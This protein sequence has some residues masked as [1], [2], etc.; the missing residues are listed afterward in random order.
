MK[1]KDPS[2]IARHSASQEKR[3]LPALDFDYVKVDERS[4][5]DLLLFSY[6][7]SKLIQYYNSE[8]QPEG[9]WSEFLEDEIVILARIAHI[10][11]TAIEKKFKKH[12]D[13][14][15]LFKSNAKKIHYLEQAFQDIYQVALLFDA[16]YE[17]FRQIENFANIQLQAR[18]EIR[19]SISNRLS[20]ALARLKAYDE[21]ASAPEALGQ[22]I[23]L[24][25]T[26]FGM[27]WDL[28]SPPEEIYPY[29]GDSLAEKIRYLTFELQTLF[30]IFYETLIYIKGQAKYYLHK[31]FEQDTHYPEVA[32]LLAFL[33]LYQI[34]QDNMN[35]LSQRYLDFYYYQVLK[36][37]KKKPVHDTVYLSFQT[38]ENA[39]F[40]Q[41]KAG[42]A[43]IGGEY[44][45]GENIIYTANED[46]WVNKTQVEKL[47]TV[48]L[49]SR[50]LN[51][52]GSVKKL[53]T[54]IFSNEI[55]L[56][57]IKP[58]PNRQEQKIYPAFGE[59][60]SDK[61]E[62]E[63]TMVSADVG[64]AI[65]SPSLLLQEG[66]RE[67][68]I[69]LQ[70]SDDSFRYL[71]Q[72]LGDLSF[73]TQDSHDE[74]F[75]KSFLEA[76]LIQITSDEGWFRVSKYV[77]SRERGDERDEKYNCLKVS[78][79]LESSDPPVIAYDPALHAGNFQTG[80]PMVKFVLNSD[81]YI[82][83]YSLLRNLILDKITIDTHVTGVKDLVLYSD[84]G[85]LNPT[86]PFY[87]FGSVPSVGSY[88]IIGKNEV[89][90][91]SLDDLEIHIEWFNLPK[92]SNGFQGYYEEYNADLDNTSFEAQLSIL[93]EGRWKP[94]NPQ[95][96]QRFKLFRT[97]Q[98]GF[99]FSA[100]N[101]ND[102]EQENG[103]NGNGGG[104]GNGNGGSNEPREQPQPNG[105]LSDQTQLNHVDIVKI[106]LP[107]NYKD[108]GK[109]L[110]YSNTVQRGFI[111]LELCSPGVAFAST[112]YP[113]V[114][115]EIVMENARNGLI[116]NVKRGFSGK[117]GKRMPNPPY[118]PQIK[119]L[120]L[121]YKTSSVISL[122]ERSIKGEKSDRRGQF[123]HIY[124]FG[125]NLVYPDKSKQFTP[126]LPE[127]NYEGA[128]LIGL[129][130][131]SVPQTVSILFEMQ[132]GYTNTSED[133]PPVIEWSYLVDDQW[134]P[135][136]ES[137]ILRDDTQQFIKTGIILLELPRDLKNKNT[138]L[139]PALYW[140]RV[141][142]VNHIEVTSRIVSISTQV[143]TASLKNL[144]EKDNHLNQALPAFS[145]SRSVSNIPGIQRLIQPLPSFGGKPAET[146][147]Q[148]YT[149]VSERLRHKQRVVSAWDYER[150]I[151]EQ[152]PEI[153][154]ATCL[155]NMSSEKMNQ[156]GSV[157][158]V[159]K[160]YPQASQTR[161]LEPKV[162]SEILY[163]I[164]DY[165][166][167]YLSPFVH[168][169]IRN[170]SYERVRIIC[171]VQLAKGYNYGFFVQKLNEDI[172][173]YLLGDIL[174]VTQTQELGGKVNIS[175]V[176]SYLRTLPYVDFITKFSMIQIA[177]DPS[178]KYVLLD[179]AREDDAK[180]FLQATKP[181]ATLIPAEEH[182]ISILDEKEEIK[183]HQAGIED[184]ELGND[185]IIED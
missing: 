51:L 180:S 1:S 125:D 84:I 119:S 156:P 176:L 128:L 76:F 12:L 106:K 55:P 120:S 24:D 137:K 77:V 61:S 105:R 67:I 159:V 50:D 161:S 162:S 44:E 74:V 86:T 63:K 138:I 39:L 52:R 34:P 92:H 112:I 17:K 36:Q 135:L 103:K 8:N 90:Q 121:N 181:W 45:N 148:F 33:K 117:N 26:V 79:D 59:S 142:V 4:L 57:E 70:F 124:P 174:K 144:D 27:A 32:L 143:L 41:I 171:A 35:Q 109:P 91:K 149:R 64:F 170:P 58:T 56:E 30:Q 113:A 145:I 172:N 122:K 97:V 110:Q 54:H 43:F 48:F 169:E 13:K 98:N 146:S 60:Q 108:I 133:H 25:Y 16:W 9:D 15:N 81:S 107:P 23:G 69:R 19:N 47:Y 93:D 87:P 85:V 141:A 99:N 88:L 22:A 167:Q 139:D 82:Y 132:D 21:R 151:L 164:R 14:A 2:Y 75:M 78:F 94:E 160:A 163:R 115:S 95:N 11:P 49:E 185:F 136:S 183:S 182:Q 66:K 73:L 140:L 152:F 6:G 155:P 127:L 101:G 153:Q 42:E 154:K 173:K 157:L 179:T 130:H 71:H 7:L 118:I 134:L 177:Q 100:K 129:N 175:D 158:M 123:Y 96:Q 3:F 116:Q 46:L 80:L 131:V 37:A 31:S 111:K 20:P 102:E 65:A 104:N 5:E 89:F 68:S 29:E 147:K 40:A 10:D 53:I 150:L 114:L 62:H 178:G 83:S 18:D 72:Y 38:N 168:L 28:H 184:L 165:L 126:L 166:Q